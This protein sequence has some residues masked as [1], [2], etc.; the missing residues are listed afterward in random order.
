MENVEHP[1]EALGPALAERVAEDL[2]RALA[3]SGRAGLAVPGGTTPGPFL[4]ALGE[5]P[6]DWAEIGVTLTDERW[7]PAS[8]ARS[9]Q[10]L[11]AEHLFRGPAAAA[12]FVPLYTG[13][14]SPAD[15][16]DTVSGALA[17]IALPLTV[18]VCGMGEDMH[19]ASL[20]PGAVGL[21]AALAADAPVVAPIRAAAADE[22]R[23]T[24]TRPVL[25]G[26][27]HRYLL[28]RGAAKRAA[29]EAALERDVTD[30]P[31]RLLLD[32]PGGCTIFYA[33]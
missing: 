22:P 32:A 17:N 25:E 15:A 16:V 19:T 4:K 9:N 26:A 24:L 6:L 8:D 27:A 2:A 5:K 7:V 12:E 20:F 33:E 14:E 18:A 13:Q 29:L 10:R 1:W 11:L 21:A 28:I 23:I 30:A 3:S 31:V